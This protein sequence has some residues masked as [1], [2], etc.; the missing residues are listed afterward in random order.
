MIIRNDFHGK[1]DLLVTFIFEAFAI[2][3]LASVDTFPRIVILRRRR[4]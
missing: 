1:L 4:R 2:T 3:I